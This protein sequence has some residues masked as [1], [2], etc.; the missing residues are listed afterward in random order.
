M[1]TEEMISM[2]KINLSAEEKKLLKKGY[3]GSLSCM[4]TTSSI[5]GQ[6]RGMVLA[7]DPF[8]ERYYATQD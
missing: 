7:V 8:I 2:P 1:E 6:A 4:R 5:T 3:I